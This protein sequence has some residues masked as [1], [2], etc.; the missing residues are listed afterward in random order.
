MK[1]KRTLPVI[2]FITAALLCLFWAAVI[3]SAVELLMRFN[4]IKNTM[5]MRM[6][7]GGEIHKPV[8]KVLAIGDGVMQNQFTGNSLYEYIEKEFKPLKYKILNLAFNGNGPREY[9]NLL[10]LYGKDYRPDSVM[11]IYSAGN[12]IAGVKQK[13]D[14]E[15]PRLNK[16][17]INIDSALQRSYVYNWIIE[18]KNI[19]AERTLSFNRARA[20]KVSEEVINMA[21]AGALD[22]NLIESAAK[23]ADML[24]NS[25]MLD[26]PDDKAALERAAGYLRELKNECSKLGAELLIVTVPDTL[27][28][29]DSHFELYRKCGFNISKETLISDAPQDFAG[30][31]CDSENIPYLDLLPYFRRKSHKEF[32]KET[33]GR[34]NKEGA[35]FAGGIIV[36]Y[37]VKNHTEN[38]Q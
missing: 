29:N 15:F 1:R 25:L 22:P 37:V 30:N 3:F 7:C 5:Y 21:K 23:D 20:P 4:V 12:T 8:R 27:Q 10:K 35:E 13:E 2:S 28:V 38:R 14:M 36:E 19:L 18:K 24:I 16:A 32:Y 34:L 11:L 6:L 31:L 17:L 26:K 33:S 9:V